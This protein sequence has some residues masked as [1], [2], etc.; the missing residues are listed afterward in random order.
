MRDPVALLAVLAVAAL[1]ATAAGHAQEVPSRQFP[2][3]A[4]RAA[5]PPPAPAPR[6]LPVPT[7]AAR[8]LAAIMASG[9]DI[10]HV[11][12][13]NGVLTVPFN[14]ARI[15]DLPGPAARVMMIN[16][17][18]A[19]VYI[20][21]SHPNQFLL[22]ARAMG[23][24]NLFILDAAGK[25]LFQSE[26][27]VDVDTSALK[28]A[29]A[30]ILPGE[31][32]EPSAFQGAIFMTGKVRSP[33]AAAQAMDMA[34]RFLPMGTE[35]VNMLKVQGSDQVILK[36]RVAEMSRG[37]VK[38]LYTG[39]GFNRVIRGR[40]IKFSAAGT[41]PATPSQY[42]GGSAILNLAGFTSTAFN[43]LEK[44]GLVRT[45]AEPTLVALSGETA[46]FLS[47][48]ES[49]YPSAV[50]QSGN[51]SYS[52]RTV[53]VK[54]NFT[55]VVLDDG[56]IN[57]QVAT[58]V[59]EIDSDT[60]HGL[61][62]NNVTVPATKTKRTETVIDLSSGGSLMISGLLRDDVTTNINGMPGLKDLP[63]IG[64]LFR[65]TD[66]TTTQTEL[67]VLVTAYLARQ[68]NDPSALSAPT[69]AYVPPTDVDLYLLGRLT[70]EFT[71]KGEVPASQFPFSLGGPFG[72][73]MESSP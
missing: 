53:G 71:P 48:G 26:V 7:V 60:T 29:L 15:V 66:Y 44:E 25:M 1:L 73:I 57:L 49:P 67:V 51:L 19:D 36:A 35:V 62:I 23:S 68:V 46:N 24:T 40:Q 13:E 65:S 39:V 31:P 59:S 70:H 69:D 61:T 64:A 2:T 11:K 55:P 12:P 43:A 27:R 42:A 22:L 16:E 41:V 50:D 20:D 47:G 52:F 5:T 21:S 72:Y 17:G 3:P 38:D 9:A 8:P 33:R 56:R 18:I 54:L 63:G 34:V 58:E 14:K 45:L 30:K 37:V 32:I 4:P 28:A 10:P 6:A